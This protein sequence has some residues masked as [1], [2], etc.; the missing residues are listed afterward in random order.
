MAYVRFAPDIPRSDALRVAADRAHV[1]DPSTAGQHADPVSLAGWAQD[2]YYQHAVPFLAGAVVLVAIVLCA[3]VGSLLL[4]RLHARQREFGM[5]TALGASRGRLMRQALVESGVMGLAGAAI[6]TALAWA[7]VT[8]AASVLPQAFLT[9]T[10]NPLSV[11]GRALLAAAITSLAVTLGAGLLPAWLGTASEART[12][13]R[14]TERA[15]TDTRRSRVTTRV[16]LATEIALACALLIGAT[17]LARSFVKLSQIDR[18]FD[19]TGVVTLWISPHGHTLDAPDAR[20]TA[21]A[22]VGHALRGLPGVQQ[23]A[24]S[25]GV[26][27]NPGPISFGDWTTDRPGASPV[28]LVIE[29]F[30][31]SPQYF[32]LYGIRL[33]KGRRFDPS[34]GEGAAIIGERVA[35]ALWPN[36]DP[37]GHSFRG[38]GQS[39]VV[40][41]VARETRRSIV[42]S[43]ID[44]PDMYVPLTTPGHT[45]SLRCARACPSEGVIRER[46]LTI[47]GIDVVQVTRL[48]EAFA[49]DLEQPRAS[50]ALA[51]TF[52]IVALVAAAGGLFGVLT[53]AV[54]QRRREFGIRASL[55]ATPANIARVVFTDGLLVGGIGLA[56]GALFARALATTI[57]SLQY[58]VTVFDPLSW[59][60]VIAALAVTIAV[61]LWQPA[62]TAARTDPA[63]LLR[64]D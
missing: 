14:P 39:Y 30:R 5:C 32:D 38:N 42:D 54:Q 4:T 18:G 12:D 6:G 58:G 33:L 63:L 36:A 7:L 29:S 59:L 60:M 27:L 15:R 41:G 20:R 53:Y 9:H 24:W 1:A 11:D 49:Q 40:V 37:I 50:A 2:T 28:H 19:P 25:G 13:D 34:D 10:L 56:L 43:S 51:L 61:A 46:A 45:L 23:S 8:I 44:P 17:V 22:T 35:A 31:A 21:F 55:G 48:D 52:A 3:N 47:P 62:R 26:P 64:E 16:L 57:A